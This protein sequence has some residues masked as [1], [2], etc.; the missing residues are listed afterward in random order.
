[1]PARTTAEDGRRRKVGFL[2]ETELGDYSPPAGVQ[3]L[4]SIIHAFQRWADRRMVLSARDKPSH[5]RRNCPSQLAL[6][7]RDDGSQVLITPDC[8]RGRIY[9]GISSSSFRTM[10]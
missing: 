10:M 5:R 7:S 4:F 9:S 8:K 3:V 2:A 1:M 6:T